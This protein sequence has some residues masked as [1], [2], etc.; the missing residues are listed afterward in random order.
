MIP[1]RSKHLLF[2]YSL[3]PPK[4]WR[5][6]VV[7]LLA[8]FI[9]IGLYTL[10]LSNAVSY[11]SDDPK[12]CVNCHLMT[13]Q[14]TTWQH[15][16]H[17]EVAHCNDCHVPQD[18]LFSKFYFKAKDGLYHSSIFTLRAEPQVI[19]A[20]EPS[21]EV[22]QNNCIRCHQDRVVDDKLS[23]SVADHAVHRTDRQCWECHREVPHG[24]VKSMSSVGLRIESIEAHNGDTKAVLPGW[25]KEALDKKAGTAK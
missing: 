20:L 2:R 15:S 6:A 7:I 19:T 12:A 17:R 25:L 23:A 14:Y 4:K 10:K 18:N 3:I 22:I 11:L 8:A 13:P 5:P 16:A 21:Q 1:Y 9:G 24:R